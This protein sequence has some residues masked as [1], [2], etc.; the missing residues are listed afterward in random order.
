M[1]D[2]P[3]RVLVVDDDHAIAGAVALALRKEGYEVR[4]D[5]DADAAARAA[6]TFFP[7][8]AILDVRLPRGDDGVA[9][10]RR[11]RHSSDVAIIFLTA[12]DDLET[13]VAGFGAG[14]DDYLGKPFSMQELLLRVRALLRRSG[15]LESRIH[16]VGSLLIDEAAHLVVW[17]E[18]VVDLTP[19][20]FQLLVELAK[21]PGQVLSKGQLL[22]A[23]WG[24]D[25]YDENVVEVHISS[26]RRKLEAHGPRVVQTVRGV[27]YVVRP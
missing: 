4:V 18:S 22:E 14:G 12:A 10:A 16:H 27:G 7:D 20:E 15:R 25:A 1:R 23:V 17:R 24:F 5:H 13:R 2:D 26:L 21:R 11:L 8:V 6:Q 9:L 3:A 19:K